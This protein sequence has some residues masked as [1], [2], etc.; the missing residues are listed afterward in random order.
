MTTPVRSLG[1]IQKDAFMVKLSTLL[2]S[3]EKLSEGEY[4]TVANNTKDIYNDYSRLLEKYTHL[5]ESTKAV[6]ITAREVFASPYYQRTLTTSEI[7]KANTMSDA[8]KLRC[9]RYHCC[10]RC[11]RII[12]KNNKDHLN[13]KVCHDTT[14]AKYMAKHKLSRAVSMENYKLMFAWATRHVEKQ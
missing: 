4:L 14:M 7:R 12:A 8:D 6:T 3:A 10:P 2:E 13:T 1:E 9:G 5:V 11:D